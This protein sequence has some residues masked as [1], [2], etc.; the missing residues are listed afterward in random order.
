MMAEGTARGRLTYQ[1]R[2]CLPIVPAA[3]RHW[4]LAQSC[5]RL[6]DGRL[7]GPVLANEK[8]DGGRE[9]DVET[10]NQLKAERVFGFVSSS[11]FQLQPQEVWWH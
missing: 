1:D 3:A 10:A 8:G 5:D 11:L 7:A 9:L 4:E 2:D 6:D